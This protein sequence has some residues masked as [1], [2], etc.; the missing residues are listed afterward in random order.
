MKIILFTLVLLIIF[1]IFSF[2]QY[3]RHGILSKYANRMIYS[4][5][6]IKKLSKIADSL[7]YQFKQIQEEPSF[8]SYTYTQA[9]YVKIDAKEVENRK[10]IFTDKVSFEA[11]IQKYPVLEIN[12]NAWLYKDNNIKESPQTSLT[13]M[14]VKVGTNTQLINGL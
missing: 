8:L 7:N 4:D 5:S 9:Q 2:A 3:P 10:E 13:G 12:K 14:L 11:L 6:T 1:T